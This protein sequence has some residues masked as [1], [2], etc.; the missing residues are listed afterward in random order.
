[1]LINLRASNTRMCGI[2]GIWGIFGKVDLKQAFSALS[3]IQHRGSDT[4]GCIADEHVLYDRTMGG[5]QKKLQRF[6]KEQPEQPTQ[7]LFHALHAIVNYVPQPLVNEKQKTIFLANGEIYNW[8]ALSAEYKICCSEAENDAMLLHKLLDRYG[9]NIIDKFDGDYAFAWISEKKITLARDLVGMKPLV[10]ALTKEVFAFASEKKALEALGLTPVD[11]HP[12]EIVVY[13]LTTKKLLKKERRFF[14]LDK[15]QEQLFSK[16]EEM[17]VVKE[18]QKRIV[19][20][21][22][23]R[24]RHLGNFGILFSGGV[25]STLL[26]LVC[27]QLGKKPILYTA[28]VDYGGRV[29]PDLKAA[30]KAAKMLGLSLKQKLINI[31]ELEP[32]L[33]EVIAIIETDD[34][35]KVGVAAP[36]YLASQLAKKDKV[37]VLLSGIGSEEL[38]AG[39]E[40]HLVALQRKEDVNKE[41]LRGLSE[42][43]ERDLY[44][45]DLI[46][47]KNLTELRAPFLDSAVI[48]YAKDLPASLKINAEQKKIILRKAALALG[49]PS[50]FAE[51]KKIS[52]QYGSNV[53]KA[54]EKLA[55]KN[56]MLYKKDYL[57]MLKK[58]S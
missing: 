47:M 31:D 22:E 6:A 33:K 9:I 19:A 51:R 54:M 37:K 18:L 38:F 56:G 8:E 28:A 26:A 46:T 57:E 10:Y 40:R 12:R 20:A 1:M 30:E 14:E 43:W 45:D 50:E 36:L 55:K 58:K 27:K 17:V 53:D 35:T 21:V 44:R 2:F 41:C 4:Y 5:L 29:S 13:D 34:V 39:Y 3:N 25:D 16:M 11:L 32:V 52:A 49:L 24:I 42:M 7:F 48:E 15:K 23:K